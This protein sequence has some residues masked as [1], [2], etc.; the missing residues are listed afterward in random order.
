ME[1]LF[2]IYFVSSFEYLSGYCS[3]PQFKGTKQSY[4]ATAYG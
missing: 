2:Y 1:I 4:G 3:E